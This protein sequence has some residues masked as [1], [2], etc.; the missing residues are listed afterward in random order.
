MKMIE[1]DGKEYRTALQWN[2]KHRAILEDQRGKGILR[3]W[4]IDQKHRYTRGARFY[5]EEQTRPFTQDEWL[6]FRK[7]RK[8]LAEERKKSRCCKSCGKDF[9]K[10]AKYEL[11]GATFAAQNI[12]HGICS[13][14][15]KYQ[16]R[17]LRRMESV[18]G[19]GMLKKRKGF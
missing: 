4:Y 15:T 1:I 9:G 14:A 11:E 5:C 12:R 2:Q 13:N 7:E 8:E 17:M 18:Y 19:N 16:K 6:A 3:E 10:L